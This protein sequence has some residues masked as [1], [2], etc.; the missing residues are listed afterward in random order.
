MLPITVRDW[1]SRTALGNSFWCKEIFFRK[2][3]NWQVC[4]E[5]KQSSSAITTLCMQYCY[6]INGMF[7]LH[8]FHLVFV[9][10]IEILLQG[11][12]SLKYCF[13]GTVRSH[14]HAAAVLFLLFFFLIAF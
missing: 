1:C 6:K 8:F 7:S 5:L 9:A 11:L 13:P 12:V 4:V 2:C 14:R 3:F 10:F